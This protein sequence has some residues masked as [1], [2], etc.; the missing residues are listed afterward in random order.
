M[1]RPYSRSRRACN[2]ISIL[3]R[4]QAGRHW[5]YSGHYPRI[6]VAPKNARNTEPKCWSG[7]VPI[8]LLALLVRRLAPTPA[9]VFR[10]NWTPDLSYLKRWS[11]TQPHQLLLTLRVFRV[12]RVYGIIFFLH[13]TDSTYSWVPGDKGGPIFFRLQNVFRCSFYVQIGVLQFELRVRLY[14]KLN[15]SNVYVTNLY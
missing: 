11:T 6:F 9:L 3:A 14:A 13:S 10:R 12:H 8:P 4:N 5:V 1:H 2:T 15:V 7:A